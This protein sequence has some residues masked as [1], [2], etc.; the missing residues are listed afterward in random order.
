MLIFN[1]SV[2]IS[3][4]DSLLQSVR[5][6]IAFEHSNESIACSHR[7]TSLIEFV[8]DHHSFDYGGLQPVSSE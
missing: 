5:T 1:C 2:K 7:A 4:A 3:L 6:C 8:R